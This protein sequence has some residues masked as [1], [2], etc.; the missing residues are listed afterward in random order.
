VLV[1]LVLLVHD[2]DEYHRFNCPSFSK[3]ATAPHH[4]AL[5]L[6]DSAEHRGCC[7]DAGA[8]PNLQRTELTEG[9]GL[10][11]MVFREEVDICLI[12]VAVRCCE[13]VCCGVPGKVREGVPQPDRV[14]VGQHHLLDFVFC[15]TVFRE[16]G[17]FSHAPVAR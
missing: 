2:I 9:E 3:P 7:Q 17:G 6:E 5:D 14:C 15:A 4:T 11:S 12:R 8:W 13:N 16:S 1:L 10:T